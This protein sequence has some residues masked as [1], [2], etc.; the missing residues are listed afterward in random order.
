MHARVFVCAR[1]LEHRI[2]ALGQ[3]RGFRAEGNA[4]KR[5]LVLLAERNAIGLKRPAKVWVPVGMTRVHA[6]SC[7]MFICMMDG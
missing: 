3:G 6:S 1:V 5:A 4:E 7:T 2:D